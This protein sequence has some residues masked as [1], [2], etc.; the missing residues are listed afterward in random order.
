[1]SGLL[2]TVASVQGHQDRADGIDSE[3][4]DHPFSG[5]R[6][7][8][9]HAISGFDPTP[10]QRSR[11]VVHSCGELAKRKSVRPIDQGF[12]VSVR[13]CGL[14]QR[15][16]NGLRLVISRPVYVSMVRH[17]CIYYENGA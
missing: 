2:A 13:L 9:G 14:V 10:D 16:G 4:R 5:V 12:V 7:P 17:K 1:M 6:S 11:H 3:A 15:L 8:Q